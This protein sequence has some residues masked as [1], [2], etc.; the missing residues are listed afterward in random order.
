MDHR[1]A[2][3]QTT[4]R[5][6]DATGTTHL[7]QLEKDPEAYGVSKTARPNIKSLRLQRNRALHGANITRTTSGS[8]SASTSAATSTGNISGTTAGSTVA[9]TTAKS[10][11]GNIKGTT[12][13]PAT[14]CTSSK[15]SSLSAM[16]HNARGTGPYDADCL[17]ECAG[18]TSSPLAIP[19]TACIKGKCADSFLRTSTSQVDGRATTCKEDCE[20]NNEQYH[21]EVQQCLGDAATGK[22]MGN[23]R[24]HFY[25]NKYD[26]DVDYRLKSIRSFD[27]AF[28][29]PDDLSP[30]ALALHLGELLLDRFSFYPYG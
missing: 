3:I 22:T 12:S 25:G 17:L 16:V 1:L 26:A 13:G 5:I 15:A 21:S 8:A 27:P 28:Q 9:N 7:Q 23:Y 14:A 11:T 29:C 10:P 2:T 18:K 6:Q 4:L 24:P 30:R 20:Y 19:V